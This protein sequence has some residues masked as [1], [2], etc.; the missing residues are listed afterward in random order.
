MSVHFLSDLTHH[1]FGTYPGP[2][3][4]GTKTSLTE[5]AVSWRVGA[6]ASGLVKANVSSSVVPDASIYIQLQEFKE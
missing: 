2:T 3:F 1:I 5:T 4:F 6:F